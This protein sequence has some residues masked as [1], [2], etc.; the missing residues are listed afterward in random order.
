MRDLVIRLLHRDDRRTS[1]PAMRELADDAD[2]ATRIAAIAVLGQW[3]DESSRPL[4]LA[5]ADSSSWRVRR[6]GALA[7]RML[8][9]ETAPARLPL[10][11][12]TV[13]AP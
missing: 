11:T 8:A 10:S 9:G 13:N 12:A 3:R 7:L 4:F 2:E 1:I 6:A 5:A